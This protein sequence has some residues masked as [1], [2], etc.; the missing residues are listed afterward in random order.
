MMKESGLCPAGKWEPL[1]GHRKRAMLQA[2][3]SGYRPRRRADIS[4]ADVSG[5]M[6]CL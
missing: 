2:S 1:A 3:S 5:N 4:C 6:N